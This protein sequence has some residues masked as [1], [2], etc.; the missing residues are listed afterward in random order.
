MIDFIRP[1]LSDRDWIS[2]IF[3]SSG[4]RSCEYTF[5]NL[6]TWAEAYDENVA[7]V[8][9]F[10]VIRTETDG[11]SYSWGVGSGD[12]KKLMETLYRDSLERNSPFNI[13]GM[14]REQC[15]EIEAMFPGKF[16]F[17]DFRDGSDYCYNI[18]KMCTLSG[19]KLHAKRN[20]IHRFEENFPDWHVEMVTLENLPQCLKLAHDWEKEES[21]AG[22]EDWTSI[23]GENA[24]Y[25]SVQHYEELELEGMILYADETTDRPLAFTI[26]QIISGDTYDVLFEKAYGEVQGAY[27][28]IN[29]EFCRWVHKTYPQIAYMNREDDL[30]EENLRKAKLSY[31]PDLMVQKWLACLKEGETL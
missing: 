7:M 3:R 5:T 17:S 2:P 9:G 31:H 16:D 10:L 15:D 6:L 29:R 18:E 4:L 25:L 21:E 20:H 13:W 19:K 30:G 8:D 28:M 1:Q 14:T 11:S 24:L 26:G 12:R 27:P 22:L 23:E